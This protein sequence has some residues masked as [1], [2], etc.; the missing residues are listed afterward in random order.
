MGDRSTG[1]QHDS[2]VNA[3]E[4]PTIIHSENT[5]LEPVWK[6][7]KQI[8]GDTA[9]ALFNDPDELHEEVDPAEARRVLWKI[10]LMILPYLAVCYAFFYIDKVCRPESNS[11]LTG[12]MFDFRYSD[13]TELCSY[14]RNR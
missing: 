10:D 4:T 1:P 2:K 8:D 14:L 13:N 12:L 5:Q 11:H 3:A 9:M 6:T 7:A